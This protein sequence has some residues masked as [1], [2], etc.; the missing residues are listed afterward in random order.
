MS[1]TLW[2]VG[3]VVF[4]ILGIMV[5]IGLHEFGHMIPAKRFGVRVPRY[6]IGFGPKL[7]KKTIGETEYSFNLIPLGGFITMIGMYPPNSG[8]VDDSRRRFGSIITQAREAHSEFIQTGDE[9]RLFYRLPMVK[10]VVVMFGG[11]FMN[12]VLAVLFF[13]IAFSGIGTWQETNG[14]GVVVPCVS[15]MQNSAVTCTSQ[16]KETPAAAAGLVAGDRILAVDGTATTDANQVRSAIAAGGLSGHSLSVESV[17]GQTR[18]LEVT[19]RL[20]SMPVFDRATGKQLVDANGLP[21]SKPRPIIGVEFA[22][23]RQQQSLGTAFQV[24]GQTVSTTA[25]M[26][27][28]L[29]TQMGSLIVGLAEGRSRAADSPVSIV[30]IGQMAGQAA[31]A[32]NADFLDKLAS[33]LFLLGSLNVALFTFNL[34]PLLPLDG[35]HIASVAYESVKRIVYRIRKKPWPGPVDTAR[36][37]PLSQAVFLALFLMGF[38]VMFADFAS[39]VSLH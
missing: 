33:S 30:G 15:A 20:V 37:A 39:P 34:V 17:G 38:I 19:P 31:S 3:G 22:V 2:Y 26:I 25:T 14:V 35:G 5:S 11:P 8:N 9:D 23:A 21:V 27:A 1:E 32:P 7:F 28:Q 13:G 10:R 18:T 24:T 36:L 29:P 12:L 4:L 6:A 16:D